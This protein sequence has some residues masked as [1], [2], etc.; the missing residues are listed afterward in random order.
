MQI[1]ALKAAL[2]ATIKGV[3]MA[4]ERVPLDYVRGL[5]DALAIVEEFFPDEPEPPQARFIG[6]NEAAREFLERRTGR[7][8]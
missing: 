5:R 3:C 6:L 4:H 1:N 2:R 7:T 8:T